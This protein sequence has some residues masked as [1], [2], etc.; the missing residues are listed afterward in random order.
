MRARACILPVPRTCIIYMYNIR[1]RKCVCFHLYSRPANYWMI[2]QCGRTI[3][4]R[5]PSLKYCSNAASNAESERVREWERGGG[6]KRRKK[7][8]IARRDRVFHDKKKKGWKERKKRERD[9]CATHIIEEELYCS[10]SLLKVKQKGQFLR[11]DIF[12]KKL[13]S[14]MKINLYFYHNYRNI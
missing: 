14:M 11:D 5:A 8:E 3:G 9:A 12:R 2:D 13:P 4:C 1:L 6:R 7:K 10:D